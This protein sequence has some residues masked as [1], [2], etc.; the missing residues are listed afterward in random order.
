[1]SNYT[2]SFVYM[3]PKEILFNP[4]LTFV[5][6]K[7]YSIV[8]SFMDSRRNCY[9]TNNWIA[10]QLNVASRTIQASLERLCNLK[11]LERIT[12]EGRRYIKTVHAIERDDVPN[13][14]KNIEGDD[15]QIVGGRSTDRGGDDL[16]I[17]TPIIDQNI[18]S[19][20][21]DHIDHLDHFESQEAELKE[22]PENAITPQAKS[23]V[24]P[25]SDKQKPTQKEIEETFNQFWAIYPLKKAKQAAIQAF[26]KLIK[27]KTRGEVVNLANAIWLGLNAHVSEHDAK[28]QIKDQDADI[29][30]AELP[31]FSTWLNQKR[32]EDEY[33][34]PEQVLA[35][36][37]RKKG[38]V[39]IDRLFGLKGVSK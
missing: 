4:K 35:G 33:K 1:M 9:P 10:K 23:T 19:K 11:Y 32:W 39:D 30:I 12:I 29:W 18:L 26:L 5:D 38:I 25:I 8:R 21:Y 17:H 7:V 22:A 15:L 13:D 27:G 2:P 28:K 3:I 20:D 24:S 34:T 16:Q 37:T 6:I 14:G 36:A 31:H